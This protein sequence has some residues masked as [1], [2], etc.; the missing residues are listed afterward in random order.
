MLISTAVER[1]LEASYIRRLESVRPGVCKLIS[2]CY[3][4]Q[5]VPGGCAGYTRHGTHNIWV[6]LHQ[7]E[8]PSWHRGSTCVAVY[9]CCSP[10][11]LPT[12]DRELIN[13]S[14]SW[15]VWALAKWPG[16]TAKQGY[17]LNS[18]RCKIQTN[19]LRSVPNSRYV[20]GLNLGARDQLGP[21]ELTRKCHLG[22]A[23][24]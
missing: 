17:L 15:Q 4:R 24:L 3:L 6:G 22:L 18:C 9:I 13:R 23:K 5:A 1:K 19:A 20:C 8:G 11:L 12:S 7:T 21:E 10:S 14:H 16:C 2:H